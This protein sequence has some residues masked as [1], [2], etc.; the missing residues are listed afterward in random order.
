LSFASIWKCQLLT[1]GGLGAK[2]YFP[3]GA[4]LED[5]HWDKVAW[6]IENMKG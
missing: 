4:K 5:F 2:H 6:N 1:F 3:N